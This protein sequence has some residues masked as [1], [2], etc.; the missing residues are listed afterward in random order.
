VIQA[1][2]ETTGRPTAAAKAPIVNISMSRPLGNVFLIGL[3]SHAVSAPA[4][5]VLA[6]I[7]FL[8]HLLPG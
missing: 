1:R 2:I 8:F 4:S 6:T 5:I 7:G 3:E